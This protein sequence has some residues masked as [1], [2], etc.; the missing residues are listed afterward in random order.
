MQHYLFLCLILSLLSTISVGANAEEE[1]DLLSLSL[2]EILNIQIVN[3][4]SGYEQKTTEA[5]ASVVTISRKQWQ[6]RGAKNLLEAIQPV[7]GVHTQAETSGINRDL[8]YL[9]G[10]S[11]PRNSQVKYLINGMPFYEM[12]S[13][14][15]MA[16]S[17]HGLTGVKR[18]EI[19]K[20]PGSVIY[21]SDAFAG[22]INLI[23]EDA[24]SSQNNYLSAYVGNDGNKGLSVSY[25]DRLNELSWFT[26]FEYSKENADQG[27]DISSD[28]QSNFDTLFKTNASYASGP[29]GPTYYNDFHE[30][31]TSHIKASFQE[32]K[33]E[34]YF[35]TNNPNKNLGVPGLGVATTADTNG[36]IKTQFNSTKLSYDIASSL[37]GV[38]GQLSADVLHMR[39][40]SESELYILPEGALVFI[41]EDGNLFGP[42]DRNLALFSDGV[43]GTPSQKGHTTNVSLTHDFP[44]RTSHHIRWQLGAEYIEFNAFERKNFGP[45]ILDTV[46]YPRPT[47]GEPIP[48][49]GTLFN[50]RN[51][52]Y[53]YLPDIN[54]NFWFASLQ[55]EWDL[56]E[57]VKVWAG[58]R[59][60]QYSDVGGTTNPRVGVNWQVDKELLIKVFSGSAF[61]APNLINLYGQN[62]PVAVGNDTLKPE[63]I[64]T[65]EFN[66]TY[67]LTSQ[68][69][70]LFTGSLYHYRTKD[71]IENVEG[72]FG[73]KTATNIGKTEGEGI[74]L[75]IKWQPLPNLSIDSNFSH[76]HLELADNNAATDI[77][78]NLAYLGANYRI[79][80]DINFH[81]DAKYTGEI[82]RDSSIDAEDLPIDNREKINAYVLIS[83]KLAMSLFKKKL[84]VGISASNLFN[85]K[86][87]QPYN[88]VSEDLM[89]HNRQITFEVN[90][91]L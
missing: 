82:T 31:I 33:L 90:Y 43:I 64:F 21:G 91:K 47:G 55:D 24:G 51:T 37:P 63:T 30:T 15:I 44:W 38:I 16:S 32:W 80:P 34:N 75:S 1:V 71:L 77:P 46:N 86:V 58:I 49:D 6:A 81:L 67:D 2:K 42:G 66:V 65:N 88:N 28:L 39:Q 89:I 14:G 68:Y 35:Y 61:R 11:G 18:I 4:V 78:K 76:N 57:A 3:S 48:V 36:W 74:E 84:T 40:K 22:V 17:W 53:I 56:S 5:P 62:N 20:G 26:S 54:R 25:G 41:G 72:D 27:R 60:D 12:H 45:G 13:G 52:D 8:I 83:T 59:H 85:E 70:L 29:K 69:D 23:T 10:L 87:Y 7:V 73:I 9:R 50:V 79:T 19:V